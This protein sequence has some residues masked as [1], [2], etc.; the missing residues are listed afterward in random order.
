LHSFGRTGAFTR[1]QS[2]N[3]GSRAPQKALTSIMEIQCNPKHMSDCLK[4]REGDDTLYG[5]HVYL[6]VYTDGPGAWFGEIGDGRAKWIMQHIHFNTSQ[7]KE[8][9]HLLSEH[10]FSSD[11]YEFD[12]TLIYDPPPEPP[13]LILF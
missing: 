9:F 13:T 8:V 7:M 5:G 2:V 4:I 10:R 3:Q 11:F 12:D 1:G 6:N